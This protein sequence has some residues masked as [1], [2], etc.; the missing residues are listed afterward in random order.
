[1]SAGG[2]EDQGQEKSHEPTQRKLDQAREKGDVAK[3]TDVAAAAAYLAMLAALLGAGAASALAFGEALFPFLGSVDRLEGRVLGPGGLALGG[4]M[5]G[6]AALAVLPFFAL[7]FAAVVAAY[8]AQGAVVASGQKLA[9]KMSKISPLSQAKQKFGPS[10]LMDF[11]KS[12]VKMAL[13]SAGVWFWLMDRVPTLVGLA[14]GDARALPR[15][16]GDTL[17]SLLIV[18]AAIAVA[19][20]AVDVVWQRF[21]H[22]RKLRMSHEELKKESKEVEGDPHLRA[23]RR[24]RAEEIATNRMLL[25][26][27]KAD[28]VIVNPEHYAVA[29]QWSRKPGSAPV[30]VAKGVEEVAARIRA[31]AAEA[32]V[33]LHRDPPTARSI[34]GLVEI[35]RQI[36]PEHYRAVA[37]ALRFAAEMRERARG[38]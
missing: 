33:P 26:V 5:A 29:L 34:H 38:R 15:Q 18:V 21:D 36:R 9:P 20:A 8:V 7:P 14:A 11:A 16:L 32:G 27:P 17:A 25:D 23:K 31:K 30:C 10:G 6:K 1:M 12:A 22:A 35:G 24:Q 4:A 3:S 2:E 37:A 19:I 13:I 28:V